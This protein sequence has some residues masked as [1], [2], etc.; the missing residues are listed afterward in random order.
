MVTSNKKLSSILHK[1]SKLMNSLTRATKIGIPSAISIGIA[2]LCHRVISN[3]SKLKNRE[4]ELKLQLD[5][6]SIKTSK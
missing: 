3:E 6:K 2:W 5:K 4:Q 1:T